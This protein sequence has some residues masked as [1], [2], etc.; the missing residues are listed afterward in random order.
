MVK[1]KIKRLYKDAKLPTY[2]HPGDVGLDIYSIENAVLKSGE[3]RAIKTGISIEFQPGYAIFVWDRSGLALR[4]G[5]TTLAGVFD[6]GFRGEYKILLL[7]TSKKSYKIHKGD[8]IAQLILQKVEKAKII[9]AGNLSKT[10]RDNG[11]FGS[12]GR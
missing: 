1:I 5:I 6:P 11:G 7:N 12:T 9:E 3:R 8:K 2:V 10:K 4:E